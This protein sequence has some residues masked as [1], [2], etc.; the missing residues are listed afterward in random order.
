MPIPELLAMEKEATGLYLSGHPLDSY[1]S[2]IRS[3]NLANIGDISAKRYPDGKRVS[4]AGVLGETK[5]K[6]LKNNNMIAYTSAE[7]VSGQIDITMFSTAYSKYREHLSAGNIVIIHGKVSDREDREAEII[8]EAIEPIPISARNTG[9]KNVKQG[10]YLRIS[11]I[12]SPEFSAVKETLARYKGNES[13]YIVCLDTGKKL[14]APESLRIRG[15]SALFA[16]LRGIIGE[17]NVKYV[18]KE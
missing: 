14:E 17:D 1:S 4:V 3:R 2:F 15:D 16:T 7:D 12:N 13:V 5:V 11:S 9:K 18:E 6:Q 8:C 10:L